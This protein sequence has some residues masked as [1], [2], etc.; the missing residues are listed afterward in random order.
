MT[1][2][3]ALPQDLSEGLRLTL[4]EWGGEGETF[5]LGFLLSKK[6]E[7]VSEGTWVY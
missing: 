7:T 1:E 4:L 3:Q 6:G 5:E 2:K